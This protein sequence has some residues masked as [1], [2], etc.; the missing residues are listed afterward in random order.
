MRAACAKGHMPSS[1][2]GTVSQRGR[3]GREFPRIP[4]KAW[5]ELYKGLY[6][7][8]VLKL[9]LSTHHV[10]LYLTEHAAHKEHLMRTV[11]SWGVPS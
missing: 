9:P 7:Y 10:P 5:R 6:N 2:V 4:S 1:E 11:S 8:K 3:A